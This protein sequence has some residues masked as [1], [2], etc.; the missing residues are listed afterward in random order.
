MI[1]HFLFLLRRLTM[2]LKLPIDPRVPALRSSGMKTLHK[3]RRKFLWSEIYGLR[4]GETSTALRIGT[5][6]HRMLSAQFQGRS[7]QVA[8]DEM[9][10]YIADEKKEMASR[11]KNGI[12]ASGEHFEGVCRQMSEDLQKA[13]AMLDAFLTY[14][15]LPSDVEVLA[16]ELFFEVKLPQLKTPIQGQIDLILRNT[17]T[18]KITLVDIKTH[19]QTTASR[20]ATNIFDVQTHLFYTLGLQAM[21]AHAYPVPGYAPLVTAKPPELSGLLVED[22]THIEY[23]LLKKPTIKC[24]KTD[25]YDL[26]N[27]I[28]RVR[29]WYDEQTEKNPNDPPFAVSSQPILGNPLERAEVHSQ[30]ADHNQAAQMAPDDFAWFYRTADE[31]QCSGIFG[32]CPYLDLCR[33]DRARGQWPVMIDQTYRQEYRA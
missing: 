6:V 13:Y 7:L 2:I 15:P 16:T 8:F 5:Y 29:R 23:Y 21:L 26:G 25:D 1:A 27:Y 30:L 20:S 12:L 14:Y 17:K 9:A 11:L 32:T 28:R 4:R 18:R 19:G 10:E 33:T 31:T 22:F 24:C 3:C